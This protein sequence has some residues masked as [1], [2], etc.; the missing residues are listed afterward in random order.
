MA[1]LAKELLRSELACRVK[2]TFGGR[3]GLSLTPKG[4]EKLNVATKLAE[5]LEDD[6]LESLD[7]EERR[8]LLS[9]LQRIYTRNMER[10]AL[11]DNLQNARMDA[12][13]HRT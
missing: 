11:Q 4:A 12:A 1:N 8:L 5:A 7:V 9:L 2:D 6:F 13:E 3:A 10:K